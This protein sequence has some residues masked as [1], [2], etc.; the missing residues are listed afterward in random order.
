[1]QIPDIT[2]HW[3]DVYVFGSVILPCVL[4]Y[5]GIIFSIFLGIVIA[6]KAELF[7]NI[8]AT[9]CSTLC[10]AWAPRALFSTALGIA[11]RSAHQMYGQGCAFNENSPRSHPCSLAS[12]Y[13]TRWCE[14]SEYDCG[15]TARLSQ[16]ASGKF[17]FRSSPHGRITY[18]WES[19]LCW[20]FCLNHPELGRTDRQL[21]D[22]ALRSENLFPAN[23]SCTCAKFYVRYW[24]SLTCR[25][26]ALDK[27][28]R[29]VHQ[30]RRPCRSCGRVVSAGRVVMPY[31]VL[32]KC[33]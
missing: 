29:F 23:A 30:R 24:C 25:Q 13:I 14:C 11:Q 31:K 16:H 32:A 10:R 20:H 17:L 22:W 6:V 9:P 3:L 33:R 4:I 27:Y 28:G 26:L 19:S 8:N 7:R 1:M 15:T 5:L 12:Y 18:V 2:S 21:S